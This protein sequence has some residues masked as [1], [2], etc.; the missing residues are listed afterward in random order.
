[1]ARRIFPCRRGRETCIILWYIFL[2]Y[3]FMPFSWVITNAPTL[4]MWLVVVVLSLFS[5]SI[6][7]VLYMPSICLIYKDHVILLVCYIYIYAISYLLHF[8]ISIILC[9][10]QKFMFS[11]IN[12]C[13][14]FYASYLVCYSCLYESP[15]SLLLHVYFPLVL[16][17]LSFLHLVSIVIYMFGHCFK[18]RIGCDIETFLPWFLLVIIYRFAYL[19]LFP[20][21][22]CPSIVSNA[23]LLH[24]LYQWV[25]FN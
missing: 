24:K 25:F 19:F 17:L 2:V 5:T 21:L 14:Y 15:Y 18:I 3:T 12:W 22:L 1:M 8:L 10:L 9:S 7:T 23:I 20:F 4:S 13:H 11:Y 16:P 6:I